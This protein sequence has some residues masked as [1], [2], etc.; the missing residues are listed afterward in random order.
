MTFYRKKRRSF[1]SHPFGMARACV[2][3]LMRRRNLAL[4]PADGASKRS[5][6]EAQTAQI[7]PDANREIFRSPFEADRGG[8]EEGVKA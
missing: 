2:G 1:S 3:R 7:I 4:A 6:C 8:F 5:E